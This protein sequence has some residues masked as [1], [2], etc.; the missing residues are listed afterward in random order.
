MNDYGLSEQH[1]GLGKR[2]GFTAQGQRITARQPQLR[3][4]RQGQPDGDEDDISEEVYPPRLPTSARRYSAGY[5][6]SDEE[7]Y[8]SGNTRFHVRYVDVPK[9]RH[10]LPPSAAPAPARQQPNFADG[11]TQGRAGQPRRKLHWLFFVGLALLIMLLGWYALSMLGTWWQTHQDD[12]TYGNPRTYQTD[13]VV[14]HADSPTSPT[15]IIAVNLNGNIIVIELPGGDAG[16]A[17]SYAIT[18]IPGNQGNPPVKLVFQDINRDGKLDLV[19]QIGDP[20]QVVTVILFNNG[21]QFVSK[22]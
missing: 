5:D 2:G 19:V 20:G 21:T 7:V 22:V 13:A 6:L 14:G 1:S 3:S 16:K 18:A 11:Q 17:R 10:A 12:V 4:Q 9:R 15:H 8:E